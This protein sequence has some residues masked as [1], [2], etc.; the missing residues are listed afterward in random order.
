MRYLLLPFFL[1]PIS[2]FAE[3]L[4]ILCVE[5][6]S[7]IKGYNDTKL[8]KKYNLEDFEIEDFKKYET[9]YYFDTKTSELKNDFGT[10]DCGVG[11]KSNDKDGKTDFACLKKTKFKDNYFT[12]GQVHLVAYDN[13]WEQDVY[14]LTFNDTIKIGEYAFRD[15]FF[16]GSWAECKVIEK[17]EKP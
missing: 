16:I 7:G 11:R 10:Y 3:Y 6:F 8:Q 5:E 15:E 2:S 12:F 4:T 1:F 13:D 14:R 9:F 17:R